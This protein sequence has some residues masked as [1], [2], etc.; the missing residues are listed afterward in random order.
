MNHLLGAY[1]AQEF[2]SVLSNLREGE[3]KILYDAITGD[4][5]EQFYREWGIKEPTMETLFLYKYNVIRPQGI[6]CLK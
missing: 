1:T 3:A 2:S 4:Q 6:E 5:W